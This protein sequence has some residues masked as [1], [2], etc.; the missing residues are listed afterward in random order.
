[1]GESTA[2]SA[3]GSVNASRK[4]SLTRPVT[5]GREAEELQNRAEQTRKPKARRVSDQTS[6]VQASDTTNELITAVLARLEEEFGAQ[7]V[8]RYFH[9]QSRLA[10][11][12]SVLNITVPTAF[13]VELLESIFGK[14]LRETLRDLVRDGAIAI[15]YRI[16]PDLFPGLSDPDVMPKA[17]AKSPKASRALAKPRAKSEAFD[18]R[19]DLDRFV[20][21]EANEMAYDAALQ[22]ADLSKASPFTR[23]FL[24]SE[25]GLGKTHLL[26]GIVR[27]VLAANPQARVRYVAAEAFTNEYI[28]SVQAGSVEAFRKRYRSLDLLCLDDIHFL[29][30]KNATQVELLHTFDAIEIGGSRLVLASDVHPSEIESLTPG[31]TNR[32]LSGLVVKIQTPDTALRRRLVVELSMQRG[33]RLDESAVQRLIEDPSRGTWTVRELEGALTR[34][35]AT[36]N[37]ITDR[38]ADGAIPMHIVERAL[39]ALGRATTPIRA[40]RFDHIRDAVCGT[41]E[42]EHKDLGESGRHK[43]VVMARAVITVLCKQ[44]TTLSYPEIARKLGKTNH[45]TVITAHQRIAKQMGD[46][47]ALGLPVDGMT[48]EQLTDSIG[49]RIKESGVQA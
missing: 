35:A 46:A 36:A 39:S 20:V 32:L 33:L 25:C 24:H 11:A 28:A 37:V 49:R 6:A 42:V 45:S 18:D 8:H 27:R 43:R 41:L 16:D 34:I 7:R 40:I 4:P 17:E 38:T 15:E 12:G 14:S 23:L 1:M 48:I 47:V 5:P 22:M 10:I 29:S 2:R 26:R 21:G 9:V 13:H 31:L 30:R 44:M 19:C 3:T